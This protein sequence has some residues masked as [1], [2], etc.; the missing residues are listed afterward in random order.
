MDVLWGHSDLYPRTTK[1][2]SAHLPVQA[3]LCAKFE[4]I[5]SR[6]FFSHK[7]QILTDRRTDVKTKC[8][9]PGLSPAQRHK[10][11]TIN[12]TRHTHRRCCFTVMNHINDSGGFYAHIRRSS[13]TATTRQHR[14]QTPVSGRSHAEKA[15][16]K[17]RLMMIVLIS[18]LQLCLSPYR[19][20]LSRLNKRK[21]GS[22]NCH[23]NIH[24]NF[25]HCAW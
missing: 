9:H 13:S 2:K 17:T 24:N 21:A 20:L 19:M 16:T 25:F 11:K 1:L 12:K 3:E 7:N 23:Y 15:Q 4:E 6:R 8:L 22:Y 5:P 18:G 10:K 14:H